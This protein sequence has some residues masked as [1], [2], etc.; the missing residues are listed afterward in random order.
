MRVETLQIAWH[1]RED[2]KNDPIMSL[3]FYGREL[4]ATSGADAEIK[5]RAPAPAAL[6]AALTARAQLWRIAVPEDGTIGATY[7]TGLQAH[8]KT[9][10]AVRFSPDGAAALG[11]PRPCAASA[12]GP[13]F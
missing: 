9:V 1:V 13:R 4:L 5:V 8:E 3:S 7:V 12:L 6:A 10:N 11:G 2:G